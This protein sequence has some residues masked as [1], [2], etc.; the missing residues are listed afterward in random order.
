MTPR[1]RLP[2]AVLVEDSSIFRLFLRQGLSRIGVT[3][4]AETDSG[5]DALALFEEHRP[6]LVVMDL[7]LR[8]MDGVRASER[9]LAHH[10][11]ALVVVCSSRVLRPEVDALRRAGV[12]HFLMK[13]VT[14][15]RLQD[16]VSRLVSGDVRLRK[17]A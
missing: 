5:D 10:P 15:A 14:S 11:R 6:D 17:A 1:K 13:P 9:L 7:V 16:V 8:G 3:V 2:T 4:A 12:A